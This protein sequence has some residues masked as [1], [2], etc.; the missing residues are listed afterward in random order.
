MKN[1]HDVAY[2]LQKLIGDNPDFIE[3]KKKYDDVMTDAQARDL[4]TQF[5]DIQMELSQKM[6]Q[7][8][9]ISPEDNMRSQ[10]ILISVQQNEKI[11]NLKEAEQRM[12]TLITDLNKIIMEPLEKL[13]KI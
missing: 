6:M 2:D 5:R 4:F 1:I 7:G 10:Q 13:Y 3:L 12:N 8:Q 11:T 9:D